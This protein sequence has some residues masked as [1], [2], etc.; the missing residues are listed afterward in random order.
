LELLAIGVPLILIIAGQYISFSRMRDVR[1]LAHESQLRGY[2]AGVSQ[3]VERSYRDAAHAVLGVSSQSVQLRRFDAIRDH[4]AETARPAMKQ[5]FVGVFEDCSC[6]TQYFDPR[7]GSFS[8]ETDPSTKAA[9]LRV[10]VPWR[11]QQGHLL[12]QT[13]LLVDRQDPNNRILYRIATDERDR[14]IGVVGLVVDTAYFL[15]SELPAALQTQLLLLPADVRANSIVRIQNAAGDVLYASAAGPGQPDAITAPLG[16]VFDDLHVSVRSR[17]AT[18]Q[19]LAASSLRSQTAL[20]LLMCVV[21][22]T[23]VGLAVRAEKR[24]ARLSQLKTEFV[25]NVT[26]ELRTPLAS[27]G[28]MGE[29]LRSRR[30]SGAKV[31]EYG[32]R[33]EAESYRLQR[34]VTNILDI[35]RIESNQRPFVFDAVDPERIVEQA[36]RTVELPVSQKGFTVHYVPPAAPLPSIRADEGAV[37]D[38]IVN[39]IDNAVKYAGE[40]RDV[41]VRLE[42][43]DNHVAIQ[44]IDHGIGIAPA[45]QR[46]IFEKFHRVSNGLTE[47]APGTGLGLAI[48]KHTVDA[49]GGAILLESQ[50]GAGS[51]FEIRLPVDGNAISDTTQEG[52]DVADRPSVGLGSLRPEAEAGGWAKS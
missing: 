48:V 29:F 17:R 33:I 23:G 27:I 12:T 14:I 11:V 13:D 7:N 50:P 30:V 51:T 8:L 4:F 32:R 3:A 18:A 19:Q 5:L 28:L 21:I 6:K 38:A 46:K 10:S 25:S 43:V 36:L 31:R 41:Y 24:S 34:L 35:A 49:H 40:S 45:D 16:L 44:V 37:V 26:H 22:F 47:R 39:V 1:E 9:V 2:L 42:H 52:S 15:S 20:T